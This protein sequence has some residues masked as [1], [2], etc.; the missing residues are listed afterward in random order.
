[1]HREGQ[2]GPGQREFGGQRAKKSGRPAA[3]TRSLAN[4]PTYSRGRRGPPARASSPPPAPRRCCRPPPSSRRP[5]CCSSRFARRGERKGWRARRGLSRSSGK[6]GGK[7]GRKGRGPAAKKGGPSRRRRTGES[8]SS[9]R[10]RTSYVSLDWSERRKKPAL[11]S[12]AP[13]KPPISELSLFSLSR[14]SLL[15]CAKME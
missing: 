13:R 7:S 11:N 6:S 2:A 5:R 4:S 10:A 14:G 1:V 15:I 12:L 8:P 9:R 3:A